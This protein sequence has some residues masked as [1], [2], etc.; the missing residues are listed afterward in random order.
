M[1]GNRVW[2]EVGRSKA[3]TSAARRQIRRAGRADLIREDKSVVKRYDP[4]MI[5]D[6]LEHLGMELALAVEAAGLPRR[7]V[8]QLFQ[9]DD[10][11]VWVPYFRG[12]YDA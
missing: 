1:K 9:G 10:K 3:E 7:K 4:E 6:F 8:P 5:R 12:K 11:E 2:V